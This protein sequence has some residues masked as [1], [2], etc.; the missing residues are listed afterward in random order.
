MCRGLGAE[1]GP[2]PSAREAVSDRELTATQR[3][4]ETVDR[5]V[6]VVAATGVMDRYGSAGSSRRG[7]RCDGDP[8][9]LPR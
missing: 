7:S 5:V 8:V 2:G 3:D 4:A 1:N 9:T 6:N